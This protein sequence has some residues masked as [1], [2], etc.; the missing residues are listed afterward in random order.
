M[1]QYMSILEL[2]AIRTTLYDAYV[3]SPEVVVEDFYYDC[4]DDDLHEE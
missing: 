2:G 3:E 1:W 4:E